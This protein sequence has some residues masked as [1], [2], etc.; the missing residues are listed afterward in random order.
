MHNITI[1][2]RY[3]KL[4]NK[5]KGA[6]KKKYYTESFAQNINNIKRT[7]QLR[8]EAL[9]K[10]PMHEDA[11]LIGN[12]EVTNKKEIANGF[13]SFFANIGTTISDAVPQS[14]NA[15]SDYLTDN[16]QT[17]SF[18]NPTDEHE[19]I[20]VTKNLKSSIS[21]GFDNISMKIIKTTVHEVA[22]P[23]AHIFNC[24]R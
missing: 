10:K 6:A 24:S 5:S 20:N 15:F 13:N 19:I 17:N 4:F 3:C 7:W 12:I 9:N 18:M 1:Y 23:F 11:F 21:E 8:H 14:T 16:C 22:V 2:K